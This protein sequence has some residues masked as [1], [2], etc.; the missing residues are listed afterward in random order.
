MRKLLEDIVNV[1]FDNY[2]IKV[3]LAEVILYKY[4]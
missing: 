3:L 1:Q 4:N 2:N